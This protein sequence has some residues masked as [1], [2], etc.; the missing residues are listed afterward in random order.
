MPPWHVEEQ[1]IRATLPWLIPAFFAESERL[2]SFGVRRYSAD[3]V[4]HALR[5]G[6]HERLLN[7]DAAV[8]ARVWHRDRPDKAALYVLRPS[9]LDDGGDGDPRQ[10]G[11][12]QDIAA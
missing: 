9:K 1:R 7:H 12:F 8:L 10:P 6:R 11:L 3:A 5:W 2:W 4:L